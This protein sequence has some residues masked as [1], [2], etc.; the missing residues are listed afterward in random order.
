MHTKLRDDVARDQL[1]ELRAAKASLHRVAGERPDLDDFAALGLGRHV[2][3]D[4]RPSD[5][6]VLE[7][8]RERD[9]HVARC[10]DQNVPSLICAIAVT[11]AVS[12]MR[13]RVAMRARPARGP[14]YT[15]RRWAADS[16]R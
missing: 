7:A 16:S 15:L 4:A 10:P 1:A 6:P 8:R 12:A 5:Q 14:R 9:H 3:D 2:D 11:V 13:T